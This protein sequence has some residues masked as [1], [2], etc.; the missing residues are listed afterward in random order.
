[1]LLC[2]VVL[3]VLFDFMF[4]VSDLLRVCFLF[5]SMVAHCVVV[6][7][8]SFCDLM[9]VYVCFVGCVLF[10]CCLL[11]VCFCLRVA[12]SC[13]MYIAVMRLLELFRSL[14]SGV[15]LACFER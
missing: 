15:I 8:I 2:V 12:A 14:W 11:L 5:L 10:R 4:I 7:P 6:V 9:V 3:S 13:L 1:M